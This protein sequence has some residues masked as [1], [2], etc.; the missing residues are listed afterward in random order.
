MKQVAIIGTG[1][2]GLVTAVCLAES[3]N[4]IICHDI[5]APKI[6]KL[7]KGE[8][9]FYEPNLVELLKKNQAQD[10]LKFTLNLNEALGKAQII[11]IC[12]GTP[13]RADGSADMRMYFKVVR[14]LGRWLHKNSTQALIIVNK[15]TV[16]VGTARQASQII[17]KIA[18][19]PAALAGNS[20]FAIVSN[21]EFLREGMAVEDFMKPERIVLGID[22]KQIP[23]SKIQ[24]T[25]NNQ[26]SNS[27]IQ[28][29]YSSFSCPKIVTN[30]ETAEMIK[31]AS[32]A[33]LAT[34]IS[35]INEI[36]NVCER[37]GANVK[38]VAQGMGLDSRIGQK[39][40]QAG[41]GYGGSCFPKDVRALHNISSNQDYKFKLLKAVI[42]VNNQQRFLALKKI[43]QALGNQIK[44]KLIGVL[45]LAFKPETDDTRESAGIFI[46][47]ELLKQGAIVQAYDPE[48]AKNARRDLHSVKNR[49]N[50]KISKDAMSAVKNCDLVFL[51][52]DWPEFLSLDWLEVKKNMQG[53]TVVDGRNV[54][55]RVKIEK[56]GLRYDGFGV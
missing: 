51:A 3:G 53:N 29:L 20:Q 31:Y 26:I 47:K 49:Q 22:Y 5:D 6:K 18:A 55:N 41:I 30:W 37:V 48:A 44:N 36:A 2:V 24:D 38:K 21:P 7:K 42:E 35:F 11:F 54:F 13:P 9:P 50:F 14:D 40:L 1:Y 16:P 34:K 46:I 33:Y 25:N 19:L 39:F 4:K 28:T 23:N 15:S 27:K 17:K 56:A 52:A 10:R 45:G 12:V 32:N 8:V 43:K